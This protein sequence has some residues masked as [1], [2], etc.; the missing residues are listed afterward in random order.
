MRDKAIASLRSERSHRGDSLTVGTAVG[1]SDM[2]SNLFVLGDLLPCAPPWPW[3]LELATSGFFGLRW[4]ASHVGVALHF[5]ALSHPSIHPRRS[6]VCSSR[7]AC[8]TSRSLI[9]CVRSLSLCG[10]DQFATHA[11]LRADP[12]SAAATRC[13][14][15][16]ALL[17]HCC[18]C[19]C[20]GTTPSP[21]RA[22]H[23]P[24]S[25]ASHAMTDHA[26]TSPLLPPP[27][28]LGS[29]T[30]SAALCSTDLS[31]LES[32]ARATLADLALDR[33]RCF[34]RALL[35][36]LRLQ[37]AARATTEH[38]ARMAQEQT[39]AEHALIEAETQCSA[40]QEV[41]YKVEETRRFLVNRV[42]CA[43]WS[44]TQHKHTHQ[45]EDNHRARQN[46]VPHMCA[47]LLAF[48]SLPLSRS[49]GEEESFPLDCDRS[50]AGQHS[51]SVVRCCDDVARPLAHLLDGASVHARAVVE[52]VGCAAFPVA[53]GAGL[54]AHQ[55]AVRGRHAGAAQVAGAAP[56]HQRAPRQTRTGPGEVPG[57]QEEGQ[58]V[59]QRRRRR[60]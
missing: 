44:A 1:N 24:M 5:T 58:K 23:C 33:E 40:R 43:Q 56:P 22:S 25:F 14:L 30:L 53:Q 19:H 26:P 46:C 10:L 13:P 17:R 52:R 49:Q 34:L 50:H 42:K 51:A 48:H 6:P 39:D 11:V 15:A 9:L 59:Q 41:M 20:A 27:A 45:R 32:R 47:I 57:A 36:L 38:M 7:A 12:S 29:S 55:G 54:R 31:V 35:F 37:R 28:L 60:R 18:H 4:F 8:C 3:R 2:R 16:S 21:C